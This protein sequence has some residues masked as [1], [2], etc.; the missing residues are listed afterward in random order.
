M[1]GRASDGIATGSV[2]HAPAGQDLLCTLPEFMPTWEPRRIRGEREQRGCNGSRLA[3]NALPP[4][5]IHARTAPRSSPHSQPHGHHHHWRW[6]ATR[7]PGV[8]H[9]TPIQ[10]PAGAAPVPL[11]RQRTAKPSASGRAQA[12]EGAGGV[13]HDRSHTTH[14]HRPSHRRH[15]QPATRL[16]RSCQCR[17]QISSSSCSSLDTPVG[18]TL[19]PLPLARVTPHRAAP[20]RRLTTTTTATTHRCSQPPRGGRSFTAAGGRWGPAWAPLRPRRSQGA[21]S[22]SR[23]PRRRRASR[24]T[25]RLRPSWRRSP[26]PACGR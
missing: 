12:G 18:A 25:W 26:W 7:A 8:K 3:S 15:C 4:R 23:R 11:P 14:A 5:R 20:V 22:P 6:Y 9:G 1:R 2:I 17:R 13:Q 10:Q 19:T 16:P 24:R 21:A